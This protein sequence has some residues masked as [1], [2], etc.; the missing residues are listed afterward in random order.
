MQST[1]DAAQEGRMRNSGWPAP[2][3]NEAVSAFLHITTSVKCY[4][5]MHVQIYIHILTGIAVSLASRLQKRLIHHF[6]DII[7]FQ[8]GI[9]QSA[10]S[11]KPVHSYRFLFSDR[12]SDYTS[13]V[14]AP[15]NSIE[16]AVAKQHTKQF[17]WGSQLKK[18]HS[19]LFQNGQDPLDLRR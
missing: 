2:C 11:S 1:E 4:I 13:R 18:S 16:K 5:T 7:I 9:T 19:T 12:E 14:V 8:G 6:S 3:C 10:W 17:S 15:T